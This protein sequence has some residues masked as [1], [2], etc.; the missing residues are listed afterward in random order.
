MLIWNDKALIEEVRDAAEVATKEGAEKV[1]ADAQRL[2]PKDTGTLRRQIKVRA[3]KFKGGGH[4]VQAQGPGD[5]DRYYA[6]FVE[7]GVNIF[8]YG[9]KSKPKVKIE[10]QPYLRPA[11]HKNKARI[12]KAFDGKLK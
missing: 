5:Y 3:S 11:L 8:P 9:D 2:A 12:L 1:A 7:L 6:S 4:I 10:P